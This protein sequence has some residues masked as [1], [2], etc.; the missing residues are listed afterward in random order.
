MDFSRNPHDDIS[1]LLYTHTCLDWCCTF[2]SRCWLTWLKRGLQEQLLVSLVSFSASFSH[3]TQR[4]NHRA[5]NP[6]N[7]DLHWSPWSCLPQSPN[8]HT[9]TTF[10]E[11]G[12]VP[13]DFAKEI[14]NV[15][16]TL[17]RLSHT[18]L[19][20]CSVWHGQGCLGNR[21][22]THAQA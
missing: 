12:M 6:L 13:C 18:F 16:V 11:D 1:Y 19:V 17:L 3:Q 15:I 14:R 20:V 21:G 4:M 2:Q 8:H 7:G 10:R 9:S 5:T 22:K